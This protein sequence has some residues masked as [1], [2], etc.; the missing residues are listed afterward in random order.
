MKKLDEP[1]DDMERSFN[2]CTDSINNPQLKERFEKCLRDILYME[3]D[4]KELGAMA[5]LFK[6]VP[7]DTSVLNNPIVMEGVDKDDFCKLYSYNMVQKKPGRYIY[8]RIMIAANESC[9]YCGGIGVPANLDH[10]LPKK[11]YPQYSVLPV[12]L[13]PSCMD[14]NMGAKGGAYA[15]NASDQV[16]HPYL[17]DNRFFYDRWVYARVLHETPCSLEYYVSPPSGWNEIHKERVKKHFKEFNLAKRYRIEA[18]KELSILID[19][20]KG[21]MRDF[22]SYDFRQYL[23]S[24]AQSSLF[25]NHWKKVMYKT[26]VDDAWFYSQEF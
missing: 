14:C 18:A 4:Y 24:I 15:I 26:L 20:R 8:D 16:L 7:I 19:Q 23:D 11:H 6:L 17:D 2:A 10:Y 1:S 13:I 21:Y 22:S 12:N 3:G 9:P 25:I 5:A